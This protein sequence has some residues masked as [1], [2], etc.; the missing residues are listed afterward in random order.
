MATHSSILAWEIPWTE[1]SGGWN[2]IFGVAFPITF[3]F[4]HPYYQFQSLN[5]SGIS[6][7]Y[8]L[9]NA[10]DFSPIHPYLLPRTLTCL[11]AFILIPYV[12]VSKSCSEHSVAYSKRHLFCSLEACG[13]A[14]F[15]SV[16]VSLWDQWLQKHVLFITD[17]EARGQDKSCLH[18]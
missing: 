1:E 5:I 3:S 7:F 16:C 18:L 15:S 4:S 13:L 6:P 2:T 12:C 17:V 10:N 14:E 11:F 9:H 8:H